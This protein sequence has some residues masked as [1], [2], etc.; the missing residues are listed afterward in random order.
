MKAAC[1]LLESDLDPD[2]HA[3]IRC[4]RP[5]EWPVRCRFI[6]LRARCPLREAGRPRGRG[7]GG[8]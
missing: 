6:G 8:V 4:D 1:A 7:G 5:V 3:E 2:L